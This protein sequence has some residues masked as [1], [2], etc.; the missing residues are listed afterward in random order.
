MQRAEREVQIERL[1]QYRTIVDVSE[2]EYLR[3]EV[4]QAGALL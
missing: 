2:I 3:V 4:R 1:D